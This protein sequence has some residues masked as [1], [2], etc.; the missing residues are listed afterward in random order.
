M[1]MKDTIADKEEVSATDLS[2]S[3]IYQ[4][5]VMRTTNLHFTCGQV[6]TYQSLSDQVIE[7]IQLHVV[8]DEVKI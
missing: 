2:L 4:L 5:S 3:H 1:K 7:V 8:S 6:R